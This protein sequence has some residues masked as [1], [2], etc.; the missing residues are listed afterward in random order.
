MKKAM[1]KH[2]GTTIPEQSITRILAEYRVSLVASNRSPKTIS[3]Y[4][5][6][7]HRFLDFLEGS[8]LLRPVNE[9]GREE[10]KLYVLHLQNCRRWPGRLPNSKDRGKLSAISIQGHV[11]AIKAFWSWLNHEG[12]INENPLS[13]YPLPK[14][15]QK[16]LNVLS[17]QHVEEL[18][19]AL[20][21]KTAIGARNYLIILLL[22]DGGF[23][24]SELANIT[25]EDLDSRD[26]FIRVTG[27]GQ[28]QRLVPISHLTRREI[29]RYVNRFRQ[30]IC[31]DKSPYLFAAPDGRPISVNGVQQLLRRLGKQAGLNGIRCSPHTFRHTFATQFLTNGGDVFALKNI[32]GHASLHTTL[33]YT[34]LQPQD[35]QNQHARFSPV[36][37]LS[38]GRGM[39]RGRGQGE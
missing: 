1:V 38:L 13:K 37:N 11:R 6:I 22:Y 30:Q 15:P 7:L 28:K 16:I 2:S 4:L 10:L 27:K 25:M 26:E 19:A 5:E 8:K 35:L 34:H 17:P 31:A 32:M 23:R 12:Y 9:L 3:W 29:I 14:A 33:K 21:R 36:T 18:L 20:D 39:H 24:I